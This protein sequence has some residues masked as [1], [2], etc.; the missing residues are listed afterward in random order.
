M[1]NIII[2]CFAGGN[3]FSE[4]SFNQSVIIDHLGNCLI[5][6]VIVS[7][8]FL[9]VELSRKDILISFLDNSTNCYYTLKCVI[10]ID[11]TFTT[12]CMFYMRKVANFIG[13]SCC[14]NYYA[15]VYGLEIFGL[16]IFLNN[17]LKDVVSN[18]SSQLQQVFARPKIGEY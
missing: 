18:M 1:E 10:T 13:R 14:T 7:G 2:I 6:N 4:N 5:D 11:P 3:F 8:Y 16:L 15:T 17:Y 12:F 9:L